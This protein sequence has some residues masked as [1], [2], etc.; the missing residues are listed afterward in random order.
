MSLIQELISQKVGGICKM[1]G[2]PIFQG[3]PQHIEI[4]TINHNM[5]LLFEKRAYSPY[6][7]SLNSIGEKN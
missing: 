1:L 2:H 3:T 7:I 6:T 4:T 5:Y